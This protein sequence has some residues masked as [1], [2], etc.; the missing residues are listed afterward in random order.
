MFLPSTLILLL[1]KCI[2]V[3]LLDE[4]KRTISGNGALEDKCV[5][6]IIT[7]TCCKRFIKP[8]YFL[9]L[10]INSRKSLRV[11]LTK[12]LRL[13]NT[14]YYIWL[15]LIITSCT[16]TA[17]QQCADLSHKN[18]YNKTTYLVS[19]E[20]FD[21]LF[22]KAVVTTSRI[23]CLS[24]C[25]TNRTNAFYE[26]NTRRCSCQ[27]LCPSYN[28]VS[29]GTNY[30]EKYSIPGMSLIIHYNML[31]LSSFQTCILQKQNRKQYIIT[32]HTTLFFSAL[33]EDD[34]I[35]IQRRVDAFVSFERSWDEYAAGFGDVDGNFWLG[36]E[37]IHNLTEAQPMRLQIDVVPF[38]I[39]AVSVPYPQ[40]H[41]GD[42]ASDYLLTITSDT[43]G[44]STLC[45]SF[46]LASR[47]KFTTYD[48]D[49][50]YETDINYAEYYRAGWW[51]SSFSKLI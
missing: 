13:S 42:A 28:P 32:N 31:V 9:H 7:F 33:Q 40:F 35:I 39:P 49:N 34:W 20:D 25:T 37:T 41:V 4:I 14:M 47:H 51:F 2:T 27:G 24:L 11:D 12:P 38:D 1:L 26:S 6:K 30:V 43:R 23:H 44:H 48:R 10:T 46:T 18:I 19:D 5:N 17:A 22:R 3:T 50:D 45:N 16:V 15:L 29:S 21:N 8:S 36:L